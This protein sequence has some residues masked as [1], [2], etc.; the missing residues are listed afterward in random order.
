MKARDQII[1]LK[2]I[3]LVRDNRALLNDISW[4][5]NKGEHWAIIGPNGAGKSML[6][7]II[8]SYLWPSSGTVEVLGQRYGTVELQGLREK[9]SWISSAL[10]QELP[11]EETVLA[12]VLSGNL[13][14]LRVFT[15]LSSAVQKKAKQLVERFG[16]KG[17]ESQE[18]GSLSTGEKKKTLLARALMHDPKI[19]ILDEV[20][21][22][23]D[24]AARLD[25]LNTVRTA[26]RHHKEMTVLFV[27]H[28]IEE[29][30]PE[31]THVLALRK[32]S[33]VHCEK[34]SPKGL[35]QIFVAL[36]GEKAMARKR[37]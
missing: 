26:I 36:F 32:G 14:T 35:I 16:L 33:I 37:T 3:A 7:K 24:P 18:F 11:L 9:M 6:L 34:T 2:N 29:L 8:A 12:T 22:G 4:T 17:H 5:V 23:L 25:Y 20:C 10:E 21:A 19:L 27:T 15:K 13:S 30:I 1:A 31:L 28:H